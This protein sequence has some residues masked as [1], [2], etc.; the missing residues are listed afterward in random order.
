MMEYSIV[1]GTMQVAVKHMKFMKKL[2]FFIILALVAS[3]LQHH[4]WFKPPRP[5]EPKSAPLRVNINGLHTT[6]MSGAAISGTSCRAV[7]AESVG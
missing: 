3:V 2:V 1:G 5:S 4:N 6:D 7:N